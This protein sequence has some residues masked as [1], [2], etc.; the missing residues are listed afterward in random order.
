M[1]SIAEVASDDWDAC[2]IDPARTVNPF[3]L[4]AFLSSLED[5]GCVSARQGW[6][7][8]HLV[9]HDANGAVLGVAPFYLK[10]H[11]MGEYV[12]DY[13]WAQAYERAGGRYYPKLLGA[14]P[15]TPV[16]GPRLCAR[17]ASDTP[18]VSAVLAHG[19]IELARRMKLS[20]VH[21][22]FIDEEQMAR[23]TDC[24]FLRRNDRQFFWR[25]DGYGTF[26][27]FLAALSARKRKA[28]RRERR[29]VG[30]YGLSI[31]WY[32]GA[33]IT[34]DQWD[35]FYGFYLDTGNRKWGEPYLNRAFFQLLSAR[36]PQYLA[37]VLAR[38]DNIPIAGALHIIGGDR[39]YGRYWGCAGHYPFLHF[40]LCYYQAIE[41][42][43]SRR[44][45][46]IEAGA[47]GAHKLARGYLPQPTC[48][49]HWIADGGF[50]DAIAH[51]LRQEREHIAVE[52]SALAKYAP[53]KQDPVE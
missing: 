46:C 16:T 50:R 8:H 9:L 47:Q 38:K 22:N 30:R 7:P 20:S 28:I 27:D 3:V 1:Q 10:G 5:S 15:F 45:T 37:L 12:F 23:L 49:A 42:A 26:D 2:V 36:M 33:D 52:H 44:L 21:V 31:D 19:A 14:V 32:F 48:S 40:E 25:N 29:A 35:A 17:H 6:L 41:L 34:S 51:Y 13:A 24:G 4:H 39:L 11:S 43:I 53:F 18:H